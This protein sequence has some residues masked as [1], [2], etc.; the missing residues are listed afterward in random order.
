MEQ[1]EKK[2]ITSYES[3]LAKEGKEIYK[4]V[5]SIVGNNDEMIV[6]KAK[7]FCKFFCYNLED[8]LNENLRKK[9]KKY[10]EKVEIL[11]NYKLTFQEAKTIRK[12]FY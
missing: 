5:C 2:F 10:L 8:N 3:E 11:R 6:E 4:E 1:I 9:C 12:K 7:T